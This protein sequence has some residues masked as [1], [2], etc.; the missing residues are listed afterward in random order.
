VSRSVLLI[1]AW[2]I[3]VACVCSAGCGETSTREHL[4]QTYL[5]G[6][7]GVRKRIRT[8]PIKYV[9]DGVLT[10][11]RERLPGGYVSLVGRRYEYMNRQY[12]ELGERSE[13]L[14]KEASLAIG[15]GGVAMKPG[16]YGPLVMQVKHGCLA[17]DKYTF[18]YGLLRARRDTVVAQGGSSPI[19]FRRVAIPMNLQADGILVYALLGPGRTDIVL[20][21]PNG[22]I[23]RDESYASEPGVTPCGHL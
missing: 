15:G 2:A 5:M 21:A 1:H 23:V 8:Y 20:R 9:P 16:E 12:F 3:L 18:A 19:V 10:L 11:A 7:S 17:S 13:R 4:S 22:R 14:D 6:P